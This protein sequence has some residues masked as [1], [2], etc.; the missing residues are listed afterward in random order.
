MKGRGG[1]LRTEGDWMWGRESVEGLKKALSQVTGITRR[2]RIQHRV[3][4]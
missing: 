2:G 4:Q 1:S 3:W